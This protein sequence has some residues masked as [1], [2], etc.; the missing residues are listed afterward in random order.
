MMAVFRD[1]GDCKKTGRHGEFIFPCHPCYPW[2]VFLSLTCYA[3]DSVANALATSTRVRSDEPVAP[4]SPDA[5]QA[6]RPLQHTNLRQPIQC[7]AAA[8]RLSIPAS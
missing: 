2:F 7:S 8:G 5:A 6:R 4:G 1:G 3:C